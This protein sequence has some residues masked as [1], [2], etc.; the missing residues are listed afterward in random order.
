MQAVTG[1]NDAARDCKRPDTLSLA[2]WHWGADGRVFVDQ[3]IACKSHREAIHCI[4]AHDGKEAQTVAQLECLLETPKTEALRPNL[5]SKSNP[6]PGALNPK[7][8]FRVKGLG[9]EV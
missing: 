2:W 6:E 7:Q 8:E 1:C 9:F 4:R 5:L 3:P